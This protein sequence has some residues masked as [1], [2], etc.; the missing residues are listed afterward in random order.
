LIK[1]GRERVWRPTCGRA[2]SPFLISV[3]AYGGGGGYLGLIANGKTIGGFE[4]WFEFGGVSAFC[5]GPQCG[6]AGQLPRDRALMAKARSKTSNIIMVM[7]RL[8]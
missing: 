7:A 2:I 3:A 8:P 1:C 6:E 5:F 4:A